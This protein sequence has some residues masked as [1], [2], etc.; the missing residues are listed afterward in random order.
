MSHHMRFQESCCPLSDSLECIDLGL[1]VPRQALGRR[2]PGR[3]Q[4]MPSDL[5]PWT[6]PALSI[7]ATAVV[8]MVRKD[9]NGQPW[10]AEL[11]ERKTVRVA[12]VELANK[13]A[14][15]AWAVMTRREVY[16]P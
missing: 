10:L 3:A 15:I 13:T 1:G 16:A 12:T 2:G 11:L 8:R 4:G 6:A 14:R 7:G 5:M 9:P